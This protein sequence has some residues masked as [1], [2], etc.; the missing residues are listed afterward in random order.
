MDGL[1]YLCTAALTAGLWMIGSGLYREWYTRRV[2]T[3]RD[4]R[5][6]KTARMLLIMRENARKGSK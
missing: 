6:F 5:E 3:R 1:D 2:N 4:M